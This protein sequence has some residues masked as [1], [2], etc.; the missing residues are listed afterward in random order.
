MCGGTLMPRIL[1]AGRVASWAGRT[2]METGG[3]GSPRA[4]WWS[5]APG[6]GARGGGGLRPADGG[7]LGPVREPRHRRAPR[8]QRPVADRREDHRRG[9]AEEERRPGRRAADDRVRRGRASSAAARSPSCSG[10]RWPTCTARCSSR[11]R[12]RSRSRS[13]TSAPCWLPRSSRCGRTSPTQVGSSERVEVLNDDIGSLSATL[14]DIAERIRL[15]ALFLR[16]WR[17]RWW[18][19]RCGCRPI[20][21]RPSIELG[22]GLAVAGGLIVVAYGI[23]RSVAVG[24]VHGPDQQAAA[25]AVWDAFLGDLRTEGWILAGAGAVIGRGR[26]VAG[27][28]AAVRPAG[29]GGRRRGWRASRRRPAWRVVRGRRVRRGRRARR[30]W[31]GTPC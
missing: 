7:Q 20:A 23:T 1:A 13:P 27:Q 9:R 2:R 25:R 10:R 16:S 18:P 6:G 28:A 19:P 24:H 5:S 8:R 26:I 14:A 17:W 4:R 21:A 12:T 11:T 31:T 15:L 29:P 30:S 3:A 22:L